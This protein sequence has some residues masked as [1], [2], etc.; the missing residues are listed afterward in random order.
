MFDVCKSYKWVQGFG[1]WDW[2]AIF[3]PIEQADND[4]DY[5]VYEKTAE[6]VIK[7]FFNKN[8]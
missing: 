8:K 3:Y 2:K 4:T 6:K 1:I 7:N 5:A